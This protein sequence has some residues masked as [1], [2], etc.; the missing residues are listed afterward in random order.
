MKEAWTDISKGN[1]DFTKKYCHEKFC[2]GIVSLVILASA[3]VF[4]LFFSNNI[5]IVTVIPMF[6][7]A[8]FVAKTGLDFDKFRGF[9]IFGYVAGIFLLLSNIW[10]ILFHIMFN[11]LGTC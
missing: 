2:Y 5:I 8:I 9:A 10:P 4:I 7:G 3:V 6:I 11:C 1:V